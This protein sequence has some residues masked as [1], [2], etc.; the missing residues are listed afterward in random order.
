MIRNKDKHN[1]ASYAAQDRA[2]RRQD[3]SGRASQ[4]LRRAEG[5]P[6]AEKPPHSCPRR[7][8]FEPARILR[9]GAQPSTSP[10][11]SLHP[12]PEAEDSPQPPSSRSYQRSGRPRKAR[13]ESL[14]SNLSNL[15]LDL[16]TPTLQQEISRLK[17]ILRVMDPADLYHFTMAQLE[18]ADQDPKIVEAIKTILPNIDMENLI[19]TLSSSEE[20]SERAGGRSGRASAAANHG[21]R[22]MQADREPDLDHGSEVNGA[23]EEADDLSCRPPSG[24]SNL[25][26]GDISD[27]SYDEPKHSHR[28]SQINLSSA[29]PQAE[30]PAELQDSPEVP[31]RFAPLSKTTSVNYIST[32]GSSRSSSERHQPMGNE[33][34]TLGQHHSLAATSTGAACCFPLGS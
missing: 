9:V 31:R 3:S 21:H 30:Q 12:Q 19:S 25:L 4:Q 26:A 20:S 17:T 15:S 5:G 29:I 13:S 32:S 28:P 6:I 7:P 16:P 33:T 14:E 1:K 8:T 34:Q 22:Q 18:R 23:E 2:S 11:S 24:A 27:G 10:S